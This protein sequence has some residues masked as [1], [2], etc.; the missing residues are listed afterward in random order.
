MLKLVASDMDKVL[1]HHRLETRLIEGQLEEGAEVPPP[2][3]LLLLDN[4]YLVAMD[5]SVEELGKV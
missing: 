3:Q 4:S 5:F 1:Q 2:M